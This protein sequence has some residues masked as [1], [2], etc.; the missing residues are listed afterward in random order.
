LVCP[1]YLEK[2]VEKKQKKT[3]RVDVINIVCI[4]TKRLRGG[5]AY[6][7][8]KKRKEEGEVRLRDVPPDLPAKA[9]V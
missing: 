5:F 1:P 9:L 2:I 8:F 3:N 6:I 7:K 4:L